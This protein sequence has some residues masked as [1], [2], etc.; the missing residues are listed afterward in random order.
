MTQLR[1]EEVECTG[2]KD[3]PPPLSLGLQAEIE[4]LYLR[5]TE[6]LS[7]IGALPEVRL[8]ELLKECVPRNVPLATNGQEQGGGFHVPTI[9]K[10]KEVVFCREMHC[11]PE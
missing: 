11:F 9:G 10:V 8:G 7:N 4:L 1:H 2:Q 6:Q 3:D 5:Q